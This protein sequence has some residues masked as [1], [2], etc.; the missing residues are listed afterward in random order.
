MYV[1]IHKSKDRN[2]IAVCD[3]ELIGKSFSEG[4]LVLDIN[5]R[6]YKGERLNPKH[7]LELIKDALNL[8]IVGDKSIALALKNNII[9]KENIIKIEGIPHTQVYQL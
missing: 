8:N 3:E 7:T 4:N 2:I 5:E 9:E 6:F 1:K